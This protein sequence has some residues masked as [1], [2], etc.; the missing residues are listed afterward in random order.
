LA[1]VPEE[2][3]AEGLVLSHSVTNN[4]VLPHLKQMS[5]AG[6]VIKRRLQAKKA[7]AL[8]EQVRLKSRGMFQKV[9]ELSGGNQQKVVFA[10]VLAASPRLLLLDEPGRGVD[11]G[12]K[13]DIYTFIRSLSQKGTGILLT[14]S[15]LTELLGLCDRILILHEGRQ[16]ALVEAQG[17]SQADLLGLCYQ[18]KV[19]A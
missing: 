17:L 2:R 6:I 18:T 15:D 7:R 1:F 13:V 14:S 3:R 10:R 11:V 12:A 5:H 16:A 9:K 8:T 19:A 4:V